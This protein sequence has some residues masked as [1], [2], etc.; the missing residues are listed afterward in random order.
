MDSYQPVDLVLSRRFLRKCREAKSR[1]KVA[2]STGVEL[3]GGRLLA[4]SIVL[5][6]ILKRSFLSDDEKHV[7]VLVPPSVGGVLANTSLTLLNRVA[8]NLNY[9]LTNEAV[10]DC[11]RRAKI[12]HVIT[13]RKVLKKC[14]FELDAELIFIEDLRKQAKKADKLTAFLQAFVLPIPIVERQL[15]LHRVQ[16]DDLLTILFTSGSTGVPKGVMLSHRN[17][18][19]NTLGVGAIADIRADDMLVGILPFF[20]SFGYTATLWL[21]LTLDAAAAYHFSPLE[22]REIGRLFETYGGSIL[23]SAPTFLRSYLKRWKPEQVK[24]LSLVIVGS[25]KMPSDLTDA[26]REKFGVE[27]SEG[28]GATEL[29]PVVS[30]NIPENRLTQNSS[31]GTRLGSVGRPLPS[32]QAKV[33]DPESFADRGIGEEGLLLISGPNVMQ[34]YYEDDDR[35]SKVVLDGWYVTGDFARIDNEGYI[36]ITG[37]QSRFSKIGGEMV[38]HERIEK[39]LQ[40]AVSTATET[41]AESDDDDDLIPNLM[42]AVSSAPDAKRGERLIVFY[43]ENPLSPEELIC[44]L[45]EHDLPNLWIPDREAFIPVEEIP[46]LGTGKLD[47]RRLKELADA[48]G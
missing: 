18:S 5:G 2:D 6:R 10:N 48:H 31:A 29:S 34:G 23:M 8:V 12:K 41:V 40:Q 14:G 20:H 24:Q 21:P 30:V 42:I 9:T 3:S 17:V 47:L 33:V 44:H 28:Y 13:S 37:R 4:A 19:S 1:R 11:I 22:A 45:H 39:L 16:P 25:E 27:P 36:E 15:G 43:R 35:T 46:I 38:P 26:F 7:G 32:V